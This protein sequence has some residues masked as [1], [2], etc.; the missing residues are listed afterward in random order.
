MYQDLY[1]RAKNIVKKDVCTK[2]YNATRLLY[3][4]TDASGHGLLQIRNGMNCG[5][6][7]APDNATLHLI[8]FTNK[9]LLNNE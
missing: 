6:N 9:S 1:D 8:A 2:F 7:E 5:C 4:E 3:L